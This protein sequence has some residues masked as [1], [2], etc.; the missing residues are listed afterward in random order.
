MEIRVKRVGDTCAIEVED[1]GPGIP[2]DERELAL[3]QFYR[4][5]DAI[6]RS[7]TGTGLGLVVSRRIAEAHGGSLDLEDGHGPGATFRLVLPLAVE[8]VRRP[9]LKLAPARADTPSE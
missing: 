5:R 2:A 9:A 7:S 1:S 6:A 3:D 4:S 8:A